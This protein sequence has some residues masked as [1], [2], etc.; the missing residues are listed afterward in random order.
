M[1]SIGQR[2]EHSTDMEMVDLS[3]YVPHLSPVTHT[4][5]LFDIVGV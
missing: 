4:M 2:L 3:T 1:I 5:I